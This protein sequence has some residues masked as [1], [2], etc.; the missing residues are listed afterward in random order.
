MSSSVLI[1]TETEFERSLYDVKNAQ[2]VILI[3]NGGSLATAMHIATDMVLKGIHAVALCDPVMLTSFAN[4]YGFS[5]LFERAIKKMGYDSNGDL[6][7]AMSTSGNSPNIANGIL[8]AN[9]SIS[10]IGPNPS[11][12]VAKCVTDMGAP[13]ARAY[14]FEGNSTGAI[15]IAHE[16]FLHDIVDAL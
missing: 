8:A 11:S 3:G 9:H 13:I 16:K 12:I 14:L 7:I 2:R 10:L 15:Q 1:P 5:H 4:D 6:V